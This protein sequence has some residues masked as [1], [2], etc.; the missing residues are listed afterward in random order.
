MSHFLTQMQELEITP[1]IYN[2]ILKQTQETSVCGF[3][4]KNKN[5]NKLSQDFKATIHASIAQGLTSQ[6]TV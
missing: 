6:V 4:E 3:Q 5:P 1:S 2:Y